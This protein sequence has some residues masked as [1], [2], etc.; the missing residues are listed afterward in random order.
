[1]SIN[2]KNNNRF[3]TTDTALAAWLY[4]QGFDLLDVEAENFPSN[5]VF[6][7]SSPHLAEAVKTFQCG[8]AEGNITVFFLAYKKLL[9]M[10]KVG[11]EI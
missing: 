8:K 9:R 2:N 7:N 5:F 11:K 4:S 3:S 10:V 1:L 6:E